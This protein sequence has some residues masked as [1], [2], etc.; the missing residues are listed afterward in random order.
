VGWDEGR[1]VGW[2]AGHL[3]WHECW[4]DGESVLS[5]EIN[6]SMLF[7]ARASRSMSEEGTFACAKNAR[8][9]SARSSTRARATAFMIDGA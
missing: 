4:Y 3:G 5:S 8:S 7:V 9:T 2:H 1:G 6:A